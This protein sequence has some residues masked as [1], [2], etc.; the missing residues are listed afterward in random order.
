MAIVTV[1]IDL[2]KN[3]AAVHG[4]DASGAAILVCPS[5]ARAKLLELI[6]S[7]PPCFISMEACSGARH[8]AREFSRFGH[9]VRREAHKHLQDLPG[10]DTTVVGNV[11]SGLGVRAIRKNFNPQFSV[12]L[13]DTKLDT[14][15]MR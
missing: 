3:V 10:W 2:A 8:W 11:L 13:E 15:G 7:L 4:A 6:A 14:F 9:T 5:L 12:G 1:G